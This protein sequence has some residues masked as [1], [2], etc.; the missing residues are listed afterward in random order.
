VFTKGTSKG[1][2]ASI[3]SGGQVFS[4]LTVGIR[5]KKNAQKLKKKT[6]QGFVKKTK[7]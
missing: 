7:V 6:T 2:K 4:I 1:L 5:R 3:P